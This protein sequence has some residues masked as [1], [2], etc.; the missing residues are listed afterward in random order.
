MSLERTHRRH[1]PLVFFNS[2]T[3]T[4][5][6]LAFPSQHQDEPF[7][8]PPIDFSV[9]TLANVGHRVLAYRSRTIFRPQFKGAK[10][11]KHERATLHIGSKHDLFI[12]YGTV[13]WPFNQILQIAFAY[14]LN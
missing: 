12:A 4:D 13:N 3:K 14:K 8:R 11:D 10:P 7:L 2:M 6:T 9:I 5:H 1:P